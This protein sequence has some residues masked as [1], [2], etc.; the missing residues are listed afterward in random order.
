MRTAQIV[1]ASAAFAAGIFITFSQAHD[2]NVAMIGLAIIS[3][4]WS[5]ASL[6]DVIKNRNPF[7]SGFVF[8]AAGAMI[9]Y[10][11]SFEANNATT[12][13]WILLQSWGLFGAIAEVVFAMRHKPKTP[14]RRDYLISAGLALGLYLSQISIT[15]ASDSVSHVG[16]FGAYAVL[17]AV[18]LGITAASPA[19]PKTK[20]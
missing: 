8:L 11:L 20:A 17:L 1:K 4:G 2:A 10:A 18:H 14:Q 9:Y 12:L 7:L 13:A 19:A 6:I 15:A 5:V 3:A 16:F